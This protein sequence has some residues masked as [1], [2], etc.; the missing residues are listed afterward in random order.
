MK[1]ALHISIGK[2]LFFIEEDAHAALDAYL[3]RVKEY[4]KHTTG[5]DEILSDIENR[6]AEQLT[7]SG[8]KVITLPAVE[9]VLNSMGQVEDFGDAGETIEEAATKSTTR[10]LYRNP[11]DVVI[12]GVSSGLAAYFGIE[13]L[14][15][16]LAFV[17][18][19]L[20]TGT[21]I[22][23][24]IILWIIIPEAKTTSQKLEM[25]GSPVTLGTL[26]ETVKERVEEM[27]SHN[28]NGR[29]RKIISFPFRVLGKILKFIR[30]VFGP[31]LRIV[32]GIILAVFGIGI[33]VA[34]LVAGGFFISGETMIFNDV[35][36]ASLLP[37]GAHWLILS[38]FVLSIIIPA[39]FIFTGGLS[40]LQ[41][42]RFLTAPI[43]FSFLGV[44]LLALLVSGF[45]VA[46]IVS[47]Y[48]NVILTS[49]YYETVTKTLPIPETFDM[50]ELTDGMH[51]EIIASSTASLVVVGNRDSVERIST[52]TEN[53]TVWIE[54]VEIVE[55]DKPNCLFCSN[56]YPEITLYV[57]AL[58]NVTLKQR[59]FIRS[60]E[61]PARNSLNFIL[62]NGS[63]A[64][65]GVDVASLSI[66]SKNSSR[67]T[68][69]GK[70]ENLSL[71]LMSA[72]EVEARDLKVSAATMTLDRDSHAHVDV[73]TTLKATLRSRSSLWY[74]GDPELTEDRSGGSRIYSLDEERYE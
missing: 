71:D 23:L 43:G 39:F 21:G 22:V 4:F 2:T 70:A 37:G 9:S 65:I 54:R 63:T 56:Q 49:P 34:T 14:W 13:A 24:Y 50:L 27:K 20:L 48:E 8:E 1:K 60:E 5:N 40:L 53:G 47:Q 67:I 16:R 31:L 61:F 59:S 29:I 7:E 52:R 64:R 44:W 73:S 72:S 33:L 58:E 38:G 17:L 36:L 25:A 41:R 12:A 32:P 35:T 6:I 57:P 55:T 11:D 46:K 42:K 62:E 30:K 68:L 3:H 45:G 74:V 51:V 18:L 69:E 19:T 26:S 10:R 15:V 28:S 66:T